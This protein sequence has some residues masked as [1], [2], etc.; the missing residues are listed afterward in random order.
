MTFDDYL[1]NA[2]IV[3][4]VRRMLADERLPQ[5][6]L[7]AGPRGVGKFTLATLVARAANCEQGV[8]QLCG[9]CPTCRSL[10]ALDNLEELTRL[11]RQERGSA[12]S[13]ASIRTPRRP[14]R[15]GRGRS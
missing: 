14:A 10:A 12:G 4:A 8:G 13:E 7:L 3:S 6:L 1:G 2:R 15:S 5:A 9:R 11:A